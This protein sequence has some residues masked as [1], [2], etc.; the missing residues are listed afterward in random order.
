MIK[1]AT[2]EV[3]VSFQSLVLSEA[4]KQ[5]LGICEELTDARLNE[6]FIKTKRTS[7]QKLLKDAKTAK[8]IKSVLDK[9]VNEFL[10][11]TTQHQLPLCLDIKR[12]K[13][14]EDLR[15]QF[16][17]NYLSPHL[18]FV[19]TPTGIEYTLGLALDGQAPWHPVTMDTHMVCNQP[20]WAIFDKQL[21]QLQHINGNKLN[22]FLKK[23]TIVIP[24]HLS[25]TYLEKFVHN[26]VT[27]VKVDLNGFELIEHTEKPV[28]T[29]GKETFHYWAKEDKRT[30]I[31]YG[32]DNDVTFSITRR[33]A[34][35]EEN[36]LTAIKNL[37]ITVDKTKRLVFCKLSTDPFRAL[38]WLRTHKD[39]LAKHNITVELPCINDH[40]ISFANQIVTNR[41]QRLV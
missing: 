39:A 33:Q 13:T 40:P 5:C 38:Y 6:R 21:F 9:Q 31:H 20:A 14:L 16:Q 29:Y 12:K 34:P 41:R 18:K 32:E 25:R 36:V 15:I 4:H 26:L 24:N 17:S 30:R 11:L 27:K 28:F 8:P 2:P 22:P 7:I 23:K 35:E 1:K 37:N 10:L 19:K 3:V